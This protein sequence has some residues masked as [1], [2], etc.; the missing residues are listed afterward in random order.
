VF[1][2]SDLASECDTMSESDNCQDASP[3]TLML[4]KQ[5][6]P[7]LQVNRLRLRLIVLS[8]HTFRQS[9]SSTL[10]FANEPN[11]PACGSLENFR[12]SANPG[13]VKTAE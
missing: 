4:W 6:R 11:L 1:L 5:F 13:K 9:R 12:Q 8:T 2:T 3:M 7:A 10:S